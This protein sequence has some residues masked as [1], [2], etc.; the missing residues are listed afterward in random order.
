LIWYFLLVD[1]LGVLEPCLEDIFA[2]CLL[3]SIFCLVAA[4]ILGHRA[5][6]SISRSKGSLT[7]KGMATAGRWLGGVS[8]ALTL[9]TVMEAPRGF[10]SRASMNDTAAF[11]N[12]KTIA[13][14]QA[15]FKDARKVD[16]NGNHIGEYG[17]LAELCGE[18]A[19]R[20]EG[21]TPVSPP[22][23]SQEFRTQGSGGMG[24]AKKAGY[25][26]KIYLS[27][28]TAT[29]PTLTSSEKE[30]GGSATRGGPK[31]SDTAIKLQEQHF[32]IYAWP[33]D[34]RT[35]GEWAFVIT[36]S[37]QVYATR[38]R[39]ASGTPVLEYNGSISIPAADA[40]F[41]GPVFS[42][43]ISSKGTPGNDGNQWN[44]VGG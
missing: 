41:I 40:A 29:D 44:P 1:I 3:P 7:G 38:M 5:T 10:A 43:K 26:F 32:V 14:Q 13:I 23:I 34:L 24:Y 39:D 19:L 15:L 35:T 30:L 12:L 36:E 17:L 37:G 16:Q 11:G 8:V 42:D 21:T 28:A 2:F 33:A 22:F 31:A 27:N 4:I 18:I 6:S 20:P 25:M 9:V